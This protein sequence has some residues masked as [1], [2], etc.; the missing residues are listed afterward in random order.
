[1]SK[2]I[3]MLFI[4]GLHVLSG[5]F[6][7]AI[8]KEVQGIFP[9]LLD[10]T[11]ELLIVVIKILLVVGG[12]IFTSGLVALINRPLYAYATAFLLYGAAVLFIWE[13]FSLISIAFIV[14]YILLGIGFVFY[15]Q[16]RMNDRI[17]VSLQPI[18]ESR[19]LLLF[20]VILLICASLYL[21]AKDDIRKHGFHLPEELI[22]AFAEPF[23]EGV[24]AEVPEEQKEQAKV[25][26]EEEFSKAI[27]Q[28][29]RE[30]LEPIEAYIPIL[31]PL[32]LFFTLQT[33]VSILSFIPM[34]LL[35]AVFRLMKTAHFVRVE[36]TSVEVEKITL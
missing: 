30:T 14:M 28:M 12:V 10:L 31:I 36:K 5:F 2:W 23:K 8:C 16:N 17:S 18:S 15:A 20:G 26:F 29:E 4:T 19:M 1:M 11:P 22:M 32:M 24:L 34:L 35:E 25:Q 7:G 21:V 9:M 13:E 27:K 6:L 33:I 3:K